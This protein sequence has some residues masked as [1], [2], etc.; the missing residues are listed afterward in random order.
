MGLSAESIGS[1]LGFILQGI[2]AFSRDATDFIGE[3]IREAHHT[4]PIASD[5]VATQYALGYSRADPDQLRCHV[6]RWSADLAWGILTQERDFEVAATSF[7][8]WL[9][10]LR[11]DDVIDPT[12]SRWEATAGQV[13]QSCFEKKHLG[14]VTVIPIMGHPL[15]RIS[16]KYRSYCEFP[17]LLPEQIPQR[18]L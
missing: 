4:V 15:R 10:K 17:R 3:R 5:S 6:A 8:D 7:R 2:P 14:S 13:Q 12:S 16:P 11:I 18:M 1:A 9:K